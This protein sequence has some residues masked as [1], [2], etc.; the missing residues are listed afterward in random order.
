[1]TIERIEAWAQA[2]PSKTAL[3]HNDHA[4]TYRE[5]ASAI[6]ATRGFL[7]SQAPPAGS[8]AIVLAQDL[9]SAWLLTM[10]ARALGL[11][12][13][14]VPSMDTVAVLALRDVACVL[15][16]ESERQLA[17]NGP[18]TN[19]R[20][21]VVPSRSLAPTPEEPPAPQDGRPLGDYILYTSG[22]TGA[23]KK[24]RFEGG[25]EDARNEA[26]ARVSA[27]TPATVFHALD[28]GLWTGIGFKSPS[29]VWSA[30][31]CVVIDETA[32]RYANFFRHGVTYAQTLPESLRALAA[33]HPHRTAPADDSLLLRVGGGLTPLALAEEARARLSRRL[34]VGFS[35]T[36]LTAIIMRSEFQSADDFYWLAPTPGREVQVVDEEGAPLP[37]GGEGELRIGLI[38]LDSRAYLDDEKAT[39]HAFRDGFFHPGDL[40]VMRQ[41][42]RVRILGRIADVI[43]I[44]GQKRAVAPIEQT[45]QQ[46][47]GVDE[48]CLFLGMTASGVEEL[49]VAVRSSGPVDAADIEQ[50]LGPSKIF[51]RVRIEVFEDFPR[52]NTGKTRRLDLR[53]MVFRD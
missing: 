48:V 17:Q 4:L 18:S 9:L 10:G 12:T 37:P 26:R 19:A 11:T 15:V 33:A 7:A 38:E 22:T 35:A 50:R 23:Y 40:A 30:G 14:A 47:L 3:V 42:G 13:I 20:L 24:L 25:L 31:G 49:V 16:A 36:E 1:M 43:N 21:I 45:L 5:F 29:A 46:S 34:V 2:Q 32:D 27:F 53:R 39:A 41:D 8:V 6:R 51:E 52:T 44:G 28:F